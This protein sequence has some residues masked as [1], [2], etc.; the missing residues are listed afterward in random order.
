M[1]SGTGMVAE[2]YAHSVQLHSCRAVE[3]LYDACGWHGRQADL[4]PGRGER[5]AGVVEV[6]VRSLRQVWGRCGITVRMGG[7]LRASREY[8][9]K[10][11]EGEQP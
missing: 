6:G 7:A 2:R 8:R 4:F 5:S 1:E 11:E 3:R 10:E 9:T